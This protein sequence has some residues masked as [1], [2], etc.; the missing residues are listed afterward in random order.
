MGNLTEKF[1]LGHALGN[2]ELGQE[3]FAQ[4]YIDITARR[5]HYAVFQ[6]RRDIGKQLGH[7]RRA[8]QVLL[9][10]ILALT[11][12]V[13]QR[14]A[15]TNGNTGLMRPEVFAGQK[16]HI[17]GRHYRSVRSHRQRHRKVHTLLFQ[18]PPGTG[19]L[20]IEPVRK[21]GF[22]LVKQNTSLILMTRKQ[23]APDITVAP[24][25]KRDQ[26]LTL[27]QYPALL[28]QRPALALSRHPA[29][30]NQFGQVAI[31]CIVHRQQG[32]AVGVLIIVG[33]GQPQV[34][35]DNRLDTGTLGTTVE[36]DQAKQVGFIGHGQSRHALLGSR[37]EQGLEPHQAINQGKLGVHAQM[38]ERQRHDE[39]KACC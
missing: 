29:T 3:N 5:N 25:R 8:F 18:G 11:T 21:S 15:L 14:P 38:D 24:P 20:Q 9:F 36:F 26:P 2:F 12:W 30:R 39:L 1:I 22:P 17:I 6:R 32:Q 23:M 13:I 37:L 7:L 27:R 34:T 16:A 10:G 33:V 19:Q 35:A 28:Q 4:T 31:T